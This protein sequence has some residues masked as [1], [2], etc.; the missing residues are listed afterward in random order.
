[1][2]LSRLAGVAGKLD[3][4]LGGHLGGGEARGSIRWLQESLMAA[5]FVWEV[6]AAARIARPHG[7]LNEIL[8]RE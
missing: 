8:L 1:V 7:A 3:P 6:V 4:A 5:L 2:F